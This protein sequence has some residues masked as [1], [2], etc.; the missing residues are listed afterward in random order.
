MHKQ[1]WLHFIVI[2][3]CLWLLQQIWL[4]GQD[5]ELQV[6]HGPSQQQQQKLVEPPLTLGFY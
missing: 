3:F 1:P 5:A 4:A 2:G 6:V